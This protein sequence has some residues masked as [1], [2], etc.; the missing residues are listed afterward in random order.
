MLPSSGRIYSPVEVYPGLA[1]VKT[2]PEHIAPKMITGYQVCGEKERGTGTR[3]RRSEKSESG[4]VSVVGYG[5]LP[6]EFS[7]YTRTTSPFCTLHFSR[8]PPASLLTLDSNSALRSPSVGL[9]ASTKTKESESTRGASVAGKTGQLDSCDMSHSKHARI[10]RNGLDSDASY[11]TSRSRRPH[12]EC[13]VDIGK[14]R[15]YSLISDSPNWA[16][17]VRAVWPR[18]SGALKGKQRR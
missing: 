18:R 2:P 15:S 3:K 4:Q 16:L 7:V 17:R 11:R 12:Q 9:S 8:R 10:L 1:P 5:R 13:Q 6:T 14:R